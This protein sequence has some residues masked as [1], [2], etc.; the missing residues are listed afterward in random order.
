ATAAVQKAL[1]IDP[2]SVPALAA[3]ARIHEGGG[4]LLAAADANRKLA[5]VDRRYRTEYLTAV[6]KLEARLGRREQALQAG[7]DLL[8]A[9]PGNPENYKFFADLCFGLGERAEGFEAL[10]RAVRVN[11]SEPQVV[12]TL[13]SALAEQYQTGEA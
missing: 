2:Q 7:R 13:A 8:D 6:A 3:A 4:N 9:A 10:R 11:P 5:A 1:T 12:L